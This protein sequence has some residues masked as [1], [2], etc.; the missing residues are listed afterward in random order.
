VPLLSACD[1]T[2][3]LFTYED[4]ADDS[5]LDSVAEREQEHECGRC[6]PC[7][8]GWVQS[9]MPA[10]QPMERDEIVGEI[11]RRNEAAEAAM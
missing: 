8:I 6:Y 10:G 7:G 4:E 11:G 2:V 5:P 3:A 1:P 9:Q